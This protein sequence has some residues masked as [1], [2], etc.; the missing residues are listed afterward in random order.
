MFWLQS[1]VLYTLLLQ[2]MWCSYPVLQH[3]LCL[4]S[5]FLSRYVDEFDIDTADNVIY[6][7][8]FHLQFFSLKQLQTGIELTMA[9]FCVT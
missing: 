8:T 9:S 6:T 1:F 4:D 3:M 7:N 5:F 2:P